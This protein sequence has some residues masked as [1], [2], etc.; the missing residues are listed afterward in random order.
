VALGS[1]LIFAAGALTGGWD[2]AEYRAHE[3]LN[4]QLA[5]FAFDMGNL[6]LASGHAVG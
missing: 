3:G 5:R 6:S 4:E 2:L 1:G